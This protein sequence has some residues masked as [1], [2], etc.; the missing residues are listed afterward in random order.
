MCPPETAGLLGR[1]PAG[2]LCRRLDV[3][4]SR[5]VGELFAEVE[6]AGACGENALQDAGFAY[7]LLSFWEAYRASGDVIEGSDIHPAVEIAA[8]I[9]RDDPRAGEDL[10]QLARHAGLSPSRLS[11][12]FKEQV[13]LPVSRFRN[14]RRLE[15]KGAG[16]LSGTLRPWS[17]RRSLGG[18][19]GGRIR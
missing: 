15:R 17:P 11:R 8:R 6:E 3:R 14:E 5:R 13:G 19:T 2:H 16:T 7:L 12:L 1:N 4:R 10:T 18:G 9:L